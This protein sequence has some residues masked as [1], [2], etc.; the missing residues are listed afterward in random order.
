MKGQAV[1]P[2]MSMV[3]AAS[4]GEHQTFLASARKQVL[5]ITNHGIHQWQIIPGLPDTG[6]Q[7]VFV[8]QF[9][10]AL[11]SFGFKITIVNRGGYAHPVTGAL[12]TG[13]DYKDE[14]QRILYLEDG[15]PEFVRKEDMHEQIPALAASLQRF[16]AAEG[17]EIDLIL[18]HYW[19]GAQIGAIYNAGRTNP[20]T[21]VWVP[22]SLGTLKKRNVSPSHWNELRIDERI[23]VEKRLIPRL[24]GVAATSTIIQQVLADDYGYDGPDLFLPP[25]VDTARYHPRPVPAGDGV[26]AF[27]SQHSGLPPEDVRRCKV[28]TEISR[29]D[30]TKRKDVLIRALALVQRRLPDSLLVV[31]IDEHQADLARELKQ[32]IRDLGVA[33]HV[34]VVG[35]VWELLPTLYALTD[36]Y[37]TPSIMEGFGMSAQEAAATAVPVVASHLV[38]FVT[39][40]LLGSDVQQLSFEPGRPPLQVGRG[41]IAVQADDV[42][43]FAH[44]LEILLADDTLRVK[45]GQN[46]YHATVPYFT[47]Q[48]MVTRFLDQI[49]IAP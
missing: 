34:A 29:T 48:N 39:G 5:M 6:G 28:V 27:L 31:S 26:W 1:D 3:A 49:G 16:L 24:D 2:A 44:A 23:A 33:Q 13:L 22:H 8:N 47:W 37:C 10:A 21:H 9:T 42:E 32:L 43:G 20:V 38:P 7:N 14:G 40:Y 36:V 41:A 35:S 46:A 12:H 17:T 45:M 19:D 25:C 4:Q 11:A 30:S 18:S 15:R